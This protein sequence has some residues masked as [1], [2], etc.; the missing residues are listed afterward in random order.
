MTPKS[1]DFRAMSITRMLLRANN[2]DSEDEN[3][4]YTD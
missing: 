3:K 1:V 2:L 4:K